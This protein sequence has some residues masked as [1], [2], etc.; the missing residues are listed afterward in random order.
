MAFE[1]VLPVLRSP[2]TAR[3]Q[4]D[5]HHVEVP[6]DRDDDVPLAA[7]MCDGFVL[8]RADVTASRVSNEQLYRTALAN[9]AK[10]RGSWRVEQMA[11]G[12]LGVGKKYPQV[13][14]L[15]HEFAVELILLDGFVDEVE[16]MMPSAILFAPRRGTLR[17]TIPQFVA[18]E[19]ETARRAFETAG[20]AAVCPLELHRSP[21]VGQT[22]SLGARFAGEH[23][24]LAAV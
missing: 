14:S 5:V 8:T 17:C 22:F 21:I 15:V 7:F 16:R 6:S 23:A 13:M 12:F 24:V 18:R 9:L 19:R 20:A 4:P 11:G 3:A 10:R 1:N 2:A